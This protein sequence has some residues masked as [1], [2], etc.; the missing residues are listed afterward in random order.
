VKSLNS[1]VKGASDVWCWSS[2]EGSPVASA[3]AVTIATECI[4]PMGLLL[5]TLIT[6]SNSQVVFAIAGGISWLAGIAVS[7]AQEMAGYNSTDVSSFS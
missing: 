2:K 7:E 3:L 4:Q 5:W 1:G 6:M